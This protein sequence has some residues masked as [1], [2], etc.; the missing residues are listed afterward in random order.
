MRTGIVL[1]VA[2]TCASSAAAQ[3]DEARVEQLLAPAHAPRAKPRRHPAAAPSG[4]WIGQRVRVDT[5][6]H[7]LYVG[8]LLAAAADEVTLEIALPGRLVQYR[9]PVAAIARL[10]RAGDA[11]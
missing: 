10:D 5:V 2:L 6:D 8:R 9:I 11:P 1:L 3:D 4:E 7:G